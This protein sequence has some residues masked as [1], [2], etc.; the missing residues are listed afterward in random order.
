MAWKPQKIT[1]RL[2][3]TDD[4]LGALIGKVDCLAEVV[5]SHADDI[6]GLK[7]KLR[8]E[9]NKNRELEQKI[10]SNEKTWI[11]TL[12]Q[13]AGF[14]HKLRRASEALGEHNAG[15][16]TELGR[17]QALTR[18]KYHAPEDRHPVEDRDDSGRSES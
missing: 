9:R 7:D 13:I 12:K 10:A 4:K 15:T 6:R 5:Q 1:K 11:A 16:N 3:D 18:A 8:A 14:N 17:V 2:D